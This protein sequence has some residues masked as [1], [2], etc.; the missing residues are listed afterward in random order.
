MASQATSDPPV[1]SAFA[2]DLMVTTPVERTAH[3]LPPE[4]SIRGNGIDPWSAAIA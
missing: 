1:T 2:Y 4:A 3:L